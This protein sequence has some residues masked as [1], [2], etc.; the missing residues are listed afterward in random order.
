MSFLAQLRLASLLSGGME[1]AAALDPDPACPAV[2]IAGGTI[3]PAGGAFFGGCSWIRT[4]AF[5]GA[6]AHHAMRKSRKCSEEFPLRL[7]PKS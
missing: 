5:G 1:A 7:V 2:R 4:L 6:A 3:A